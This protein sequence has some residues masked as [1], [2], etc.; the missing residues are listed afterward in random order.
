MGDAVSFVHSLY[1]A[2]KLFRIYLSFESFLKVQLH[3]L[4]HSLLILSNTLDNFKAYKVNLI[5]LIKNE[6]IER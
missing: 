3:L 2:L 4:S 6:T 5:Y 1:S